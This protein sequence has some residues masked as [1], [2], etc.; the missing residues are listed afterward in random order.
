MNIR[1]CELYIFRISHHVGTH[2]LKYAVIKS[3]WFIVA[4]KDLVSEPTCQGETFAR[5]GN[6]EAENVGRE[7][8]SYG[9]IRL[10]SGDLNPRGTL[11][12]RNAVSSRFDASSRNHSA[13]CEGMRAINV[14]YRLE[15]D[16]NESVIESHIKNNFGY[17]KRA[18]LKIT[19]VC[20]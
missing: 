1:R 2:H 7:T 10:A 8:A 4:G 20:W 12:R 19:A 9:A 11:S 17:A 15:T 18:G 13:S 6:R 16:W 3:N 5:S 14:R